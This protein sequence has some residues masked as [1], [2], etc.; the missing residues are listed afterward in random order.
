[1]T[2][3]VPSQNNKK[4][5]GADVTI[6]ERSHQLDPSSADKYNLRLESAKTPDLSTPAKHKAKKSPSPGIRGVLCERDNPV[7]ILAQP[8][9]P[10]K[11][12]LDT[13]R[14][15]GKKLRIKSPRKIQHNAAADFTAVKDNRGSPQDELA[16]LTL[17]L[18]VLAQKEESPELASI[19][20]RLRTLQSAFETSTIE[21]SPLRIGEAFAND[22][23]S[24]SAVSERKINQLQKQLAQAESENT[25]LYARTNKELMNVFEQVRNGS[26]VDELRRSVVQEMEEAKKWREEAKKLKRENL[27]LRTRLQLDG[28][29][30]LAEEKLECMLKLEP[31]V[32]DDYATYFTEDASK[33]KVKHD[34]EEN[35]SYDD[36]D[37][38]D[39]DLG[40]AKENLPPVLRSQKSMSIMSR[41][42]PRA[43]VRN[44]E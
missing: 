39:H 29:E 13:S 1:M 27:L 19:A 23:V 24:A 34:E 44:G 43:L 3:A 16:S 38:D 9:S 4:A 26:G 31:I 12:V 18:T 30:E 8:S 10:V 11:Y 25:A 37:N 15:S 5:L 22:H 2:P 32:D 21:T 42:R 33:I 20:D 17:L 40:R 14:S 28:T 7:N 35:K 36:D 41:G 6:R